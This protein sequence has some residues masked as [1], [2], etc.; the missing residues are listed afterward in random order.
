MITNNVN[1]KIF[2]SIAEAPIHSKEIIAVKIDEALIVKKGMT[3]G[4]PTVDLCMTDKDGNKY[5]AL[6]TGK[7][8]NSIAQ[9]VRGVSTH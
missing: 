1:V 6:V 9:V 2:N 3:S 4:A 5:V 7:I 8:L